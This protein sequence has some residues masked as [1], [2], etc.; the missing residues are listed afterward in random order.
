MFRRFIHVERKVINKLY[1]DMRD[2]LC[3]VSIIYAPKNSG[4]TYALKRFQ[5]ATISVIHFNHID[6]ISN[7]FLKKIENHS[8]NSL[9]I[10]VINGFDNVW[11][12]ELYEARIANFAAFSRRLGTF[13]VYIPINELKTANEMKK[14]NDG[15]KIIMPINPIEWKLTR[16][17]IVNYLMQSNVNFN[18]EV[19]EY[20][21][22]AGTFEILNMIEKGSS[23]DL[24]KTRSL[25][26]EKTWIQK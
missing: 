16:D 2:E 3:S 7:K 9:T 20:A 11:N 1:E 4:K 14:V 8:E 26:I 6:D 5:D 10:C 13:K 19:L 23:L 22:R 21:Q 15:S 24:I 18:R 12:R 17:E 25:E